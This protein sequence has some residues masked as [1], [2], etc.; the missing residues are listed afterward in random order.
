MR[1]SRGADGWSITATPDAQIW[2]NQGLNLLHDFWD[3]ESA[4]AFE[5]GIRVDPH[6]AMCYWGLYK[7]ESFGH[8]NAKDYALPALAKAVALKGHVGSAERLYIE[9]A[10]AHEDAIKAAGKRQP[11]FSKVA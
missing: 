9:A 6:C 11:D 10:A 1:S 3:Y 7:A 5:Q 2:F 4:R 8:S